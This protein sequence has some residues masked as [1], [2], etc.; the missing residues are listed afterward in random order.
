MKAMTLRLPDDVH[1][2]LRQE[3]FDQRTS[4]TALIVEALVR[5]APVADRGDERNRIASALR[6]Q[7]LMRFDEFGPH[8]QRGAAFWD[9]YTGILENR[10]APADE[11]ENGKGGQS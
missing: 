1:E 4:I 10:L 3:A 5:P 9:A 6:D 8:D 11:V 2:R 7:A